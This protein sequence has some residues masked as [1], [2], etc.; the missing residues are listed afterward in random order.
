MSDIDEAYGEQ[1]TTGGHDQLDP[2]RNPEAKPPN[3][4]EVSIV[5]DNYGGTTVDGKKVLKMWYSTTGWIWY[6]V[7]ETEPG[8]LVWLR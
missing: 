2:P 7:E 1:F 8:L 6:G 3:A 5:N 4:E